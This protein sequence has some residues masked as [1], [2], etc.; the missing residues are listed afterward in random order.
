MGKKK[1]KAPV[2]SQGTRFWPDVYA[3]IKQLAQQ[4]GRSFNAEVNWALQQYIAQQKGEQSRD[5]QGV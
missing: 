5:Q 4:H 2:V 1:A 3:G